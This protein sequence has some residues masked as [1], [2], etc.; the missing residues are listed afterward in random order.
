MSDLLNI[1]FY[2][3]AKFSLRL[4]R[5]YFLLFLLSAWA[6]S[7]TIIRKAPK[8]F[9]YVVK[10]TIEV[11]GG[12]FTK[13]EKSNILSRLENQLEDSV[14]VKSKRSFIVFNTISK[15]PAYNPLYAATSAGNME[16]SMFHLGYYNASV[17]FKPD[18]N[19]RKVTIHY[20]VQ[21]G[22][23]TRIDTMRY[24]LVVPE[25][26]NIADQSAS[27]TYL[28]KNAL[29]SKTA[30]EA[31]INRLVDTFRN[32]GY[33]KITSADIRL[34]G[35]T[36]IAALTTISDDPFEQLELLA[37]AEAQRDSPTIRLAMILNV[38][39][40]STKL[41]PFTIGRVIILPDYLPGDDLNDPTMFQRYH[42]DV[43]IRFKQDLFSSS[44]LVRNL[45]LKSGNI[46]RQE[47]YNRTIS[48]Y[49]QA[50]VWETVNIRIIE[51]TD[52]PQTIDIVVE[53]MP[54]KKFGF[55]AALE[56]S[57]SANSNTNN[58]LAGNLFGLSGNLS[59]TNRNVR[60]EAI[61]M[62]TRLRAGVELNNNNRQKDT[63]LINSNE[64]SISNN[65]S[66]P[67]LI[68]PI[69]KIN[70]RNPESAETFINSYAA[71]NDRLDLFSTQTF[72]FNFGWSFINK[73]NTR[74]TF[75]PV[76]IE[77]NYLYNQT[78]SFTRILDSIPF[79]RY[80]YNTAFIAGMNMGL[81]HTKVTPGANL[82]TTRERFIRVNV[83][84]SGLTWGAIPV[85]KKYKR[86]YIKTD[87]EF[88]HTVNYS[89]N[90]S[91]VARFFTGIGLAF[92]KDT[93]LP[94][95]K[96]YFSGGSNG[97][98]GWP[99][100]GIGRGSE[101][102]IPFGQNIFNDRTADFQLETNLEYRYIIARIIPNTLTLRGALFVD[103]GNIWNLKNTHPDGSLDSSQFKFK[104]L[105]KEL[106]V[107]VGTGFRL[108]FNYFVLR[109][110][111]GFR[112]KKPELSNVN[113]GW[114][115]PKI[116][117]DD[118]FQKIFGRKEES[119]K[120]RYENFNF[121]IGISYPF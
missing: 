62:T 70:Q 3:K 6:S 28:K 89:N 12:N 9:P 29:I 82:N 18:T 72:N 25:L 119:R 90:T 116:G 44:F 74:I 35:D 66:F 109:F 8:N 113:N 100:R 24:R 48:N 101:Q 64:L 58:A 110:D 21:A 63:R 36:T 94:F 88:K 15:P 40:D 38:P 96:Q 111:L 114:N 51:R 91:L 107:S 50:A 103:A 49:T 112:V 99:I 13:L 31:E 98:R 65:I 14:Q 84:E 68:T 105:Y 102:L 93:T 73:K 52:K 69:K 97:M 120:W 16:A 41:K 59:L 118:M 106:G 26:Q 67:R 7:C 33:Y 76:N 5:F 22:K 42:Q 81:S 11:K 46:F 75:K 17:D 2:F 85:A 77:F 4:T 39:E 117:F 54:A 1:P 27:K 78:D 34:L 45:R 19:K 20:T 23:A 10:N 32:H 43:A 60:R 71:L 115:L 95:F 37:Q 57:Y 47:D 104:N 53:L 121:T 108:D 56:S 92:G 83:E 30:V 79:L 80:S 87:F 55:E 61:N 86:R